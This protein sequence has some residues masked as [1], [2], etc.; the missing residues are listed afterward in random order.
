ML[1]RLTASERESFGV[2][3]AAGPFSRERAV[4]EG[5]ERFAMLHAPPDIRGRARQTLDAPALDLDAVAALT[6][7]SDERSAD[8]FRFPEMTDALALDWSWAVRASTGDRVLVPTTLV[9][10][11][12]K[13]SVRL[14]DATSNGYACHPDADDAKL[15]A[16][17]EVVERDA[18]LASWYAGLELAIVA[19]A[20]APAGA[21]VFV[22]T[23]DI[24]LP[25]VLVASCLADG[26]LRIG[27]AAGTSF[28]IALTRALFE[29][30][31]QLIVPPNLQLGAPDL[32]RG[33]RGYGPRD[34]VAFYT[35]ARGH[36]LLER[37]NE[38]ARPVKLGDMQARWP[39]RAPV[40]KHALGAAIGVLRT[41]GLDVLFVDRSLPELFGR[42]CHVTRAL[43]PGAVEMSWG[44]IY[45]RLASPRVTRWIAGGAELSTWP[46]PFG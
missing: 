35:G 13:G 36:A 28:D 1:A 5:V 14:V 40:A 27:S 12:S 3:I 10:R 30:Q 24:D 8:G 44:M 6:F 19:D 18:L 41:A 37:W 25:V 22:A 17:L 26:S 38:A 45:R 7:R 23:Q 32:D 39:D 31:G 2:A 20:N 15:R 21:L 4:A 9:G 34:H 29:I 42:H 43:V 16:L 46:H 33:H 11:P